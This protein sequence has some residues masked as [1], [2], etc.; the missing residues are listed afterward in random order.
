VT[1]L[2]EPREPVSICLADGEAMQSETLVVDRMR[3]IE[4]AMRGTA[5]RLVKQIGARRRRAG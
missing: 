3:Q 5:I 1:H 4:T 2:G